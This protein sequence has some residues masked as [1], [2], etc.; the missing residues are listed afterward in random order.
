MPGTTTPVPGT[1]EPPAAGTTTPA[2]GTKELPAAGTTA[3]APGTT[4]PPAA[5]TTTAPG[6]LAQILWTTE[7]PFANIVHHG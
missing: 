6:T 7:E 4:S 3:P 5:G 2:Q 1:T